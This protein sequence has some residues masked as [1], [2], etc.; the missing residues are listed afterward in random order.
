MVATIEGFHYSTSISKTDEMDLDFE[1]AARKEV[2]CL[3]EKITD[4]EKETM[5][6]HS[7]IAVAK[8]EVDNGT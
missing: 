4:M 8:A 3:Q 7:A 6:L 2:M 1:N 5:D